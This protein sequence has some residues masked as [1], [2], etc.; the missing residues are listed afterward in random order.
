MKYERHNHWWCETNLE[1]QGW[2]NSQI[3]SPL[4]LGYKPI[5]RGRGSEKN[6]WDSK[7]GTR[8]Q[9]PP[10]KKITKEHL[11]G[12][13]RKW[14]KSSKKRTSSKTR[15]ML[16]KRVWLED[17]RS[18]EYSENLGKENFSMMKERQRRILRKI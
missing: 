18:W 1:R 5:R 11:V 14:I 17:G 8:N 15:R 13:K 10:E 9:R 6:C 3:Y 12:S 2:T 4:S 16:T 7:E